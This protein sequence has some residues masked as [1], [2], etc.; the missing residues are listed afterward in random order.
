MRVSGKKNAF[1]FGGDVEE[2]EED[3]SHLGQWVRADVLKVT[4]YGSRTSGNEEFPSAVAPD[5]AVISVGRENSFGHPS[6]EMLGMLS[7]MKV[8]R[9]DRDGAVKMA[10]TESALD[11]KTYRDYSLQEADC[12]KTEWHNCRRLLSRW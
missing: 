12:L 7:G 3:I 6:P 10:E 4:H 9:T 5:V 2:G 8:F 11:I 1:L